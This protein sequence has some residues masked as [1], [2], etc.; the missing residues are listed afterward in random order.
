MTRFLLQTNNFVFY[1]NYLLLY[2]YLS[3]CASSVQLFIARFH[4]YCIVHL[5]YLGSTKAIY[6]CILT[7]YVYYLN[8]IIDAF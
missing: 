2:K 5:R 8:K 3:I 7:H 1:S 6:N 4:V